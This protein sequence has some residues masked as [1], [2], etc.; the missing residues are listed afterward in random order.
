[1]AQTTFK[2]ESPKKVS[3]E[4]IKKTAKAADERAAMFTIPAETGKVLT[5]T[6]EFFEQAWT[7]YEDN[8]KMSSGTTIMVGVK[9]L[10]QPLRLS[11]FRSRTL[12]EETGN[13]TFEAC[14]KKEASFV[15]MIEG[16]T[17]GKKVIVSRGDYVY[18]GAARARQIDTLVWAE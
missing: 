5:L 15:E 6:G 11:F 18:P 8:K 1:M 10:P 4:D 3:L 16:L 14:F 2:A 17:K 13:K 12:H 7:R 9:E